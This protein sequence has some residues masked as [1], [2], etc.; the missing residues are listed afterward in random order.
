MSVMIRFAN[1]EAA[2]EFAINAE[3]IWEVFRD[4]RDPRLADM[5]ILCDAL[6]IESALQRHPVGE[7]VAI[8]P[9][10][11]RELAEIVAENCVELAETIAPGDISITL[12]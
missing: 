12:A 3:G 10:R 1:R 4:D 11:V 9:D 5:D 6:A 8:V 7:I 2:E